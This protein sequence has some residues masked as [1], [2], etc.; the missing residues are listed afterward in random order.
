MI[1]LRN[2]STDTC[3]NGGE[4]PIRAPS[5]DP[6]PLS[7][8]LS[9]LTCRCTNGFVQ[10]I[11]P[12]G[13]DVPDPDTDDLSPVVKRSVSITSM[14]CNSIDHSENA[15]RAEALA[16]IEMELEAVR[17]ILEA[18]R[19]CASEPGRKRESRKAYQLVCQKNEQT[20][21]FHNH[22]HVNKSQTLLKLE[23]CGSLVKLP[24]CKFKVT[25]LLNG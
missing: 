19:K 1:S 13:D 14:G 8:S 18:N 11:S 5:S 12:D 2:S 15:D 9:D 6:T 25:R 21:S 3:A 10:V 7:I 24:E 16:W 23:A 17:K 20:V 4:A 22:W